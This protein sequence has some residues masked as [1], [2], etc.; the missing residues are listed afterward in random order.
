MLAGNVININIVIMSI[1]TCSPPI[2]MLIIIFPGALVSLP[3]FSVDY[4]RID[5]LNFSVACRT[6][7]AK[8]TLPTWSS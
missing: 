7:P 5:P 2:M 3:D 4:F 6:R 8:K 1:R